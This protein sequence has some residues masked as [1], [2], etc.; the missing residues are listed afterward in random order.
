MLLANILPIQI[1]LKIFD[2]QKFYVTCNVPAKVSASIN[3]ALLKFFQAM[4]SKP[5]LPD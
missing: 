3:M 1:L 2:L 5:D 4:K